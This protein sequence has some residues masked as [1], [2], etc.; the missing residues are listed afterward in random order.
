[1]KKYEIESSNIKDAAYDVETKTLVV[2]FN[3]GASYSYEDVEPDSVCRL[4]FSD[5]AGNAFPDSIKKHK[6]TQL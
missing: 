2:T 1:M 3:S 5:S 4:L 6:C